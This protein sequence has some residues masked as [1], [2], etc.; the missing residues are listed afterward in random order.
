MIQFFWDVTPCRL[1]VTDVLEELFWLQGL[2]VQE[3]NVRPSKGRDSTLLPS[4]AISHSTGRNIHKK[5]YLHHHC[6]KLESRKSISIEGAV[7]V[8]QS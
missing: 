3:S 7:Y 4:V 1:I 8:E 2:K 6:Q 5:L